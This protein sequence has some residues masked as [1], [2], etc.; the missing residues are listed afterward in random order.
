M[1]AP[2]EDRGFDDGDGLQMGMPIKHWNRVGSQQT[3]IE[4][5][6]GRCVGLG[7]K[8]AEG[9]NTRCVGFGVKDADS[10]K[11][12]VGLGV[13]DADRSIRCVGLGL[14]EVLMLGLLQIGA[15]EGQSKS[16]GSQQS[17]SCPV[18]IG[19]IDA[20]QMGANDGHVMS[21]GSQHAFGGIEGPPP[22]GQ[23]GTKS[24]QGNFAGSQH[25]PAGNEGMAVGHRGTVES[26]HCVRDGSQQS[27]RAVMDAEAEGQMGA[28]VG[29]SIFVGSQQFIGGIDGRLDID[30]VEAVE[31]Q[32]GMF[33][34][35]QSTREGSQHG[36]GYCVGFALIEPE[37]DGRGV[38]AGVLETEGQI[39]DEAAQFIV[40]GSQHPPLPV[41][42][43]L[44]L[45]V[46]EVFFAVIVGDCVGRDVD[47]EV[48]EAEGQ[49]IES[50]GQ[51]IVIGSQHEP[52]GDLGV[53]VG[54]G[55]GVND[56]Q[57]GI[58]GSQRIL[59]GS[60][61]PLSK[62]VALAETSR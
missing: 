41:L 40:A 17:A 15:S 23:R 48:I 49:I 47:A 55:V 5:G 56:G 26:E 38:D 28:P 25:A 10:S 59:V 21:R 16:V 51:F 52:V 30:A 62:G 2:T 37:K 54:V 6:M 31:V 46:L 12:C 44:P 11:R 42:P 18:G 43:V 13:K 7:V 29:Q 1:D 27:R 50:E 8:D 36:A 4:D 53:G 20:E 34:V 14:I 60:Q 57:I 39:M 45:P 61:H 33:T 24:G 58:A 22:G 32:M 9:L 3:V 19:V 35:E